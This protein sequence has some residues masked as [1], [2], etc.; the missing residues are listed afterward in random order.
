MTGTQT[1]SL[2]FSFCHYCKAYLLKG[3]DL[4]FR[5]SHLSHY[6]CENAQLKIC[7][8]N[9]NMWSLWDQNQICQAQTNFFGNV[10]HAIIR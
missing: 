5:I 9:I 3:D 4:R 7:R 8:E 6:L 2:S 10:I 1:H